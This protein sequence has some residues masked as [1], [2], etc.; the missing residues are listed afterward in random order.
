MTQP[1]F[2]IFSYL[3]NPRIYKATIAGRLCGV[4]VDIVGA[5]PPELADWLWDFNARSLDEAGKQQHADSARQARTGFGGTLYKTDAFLA[6]HPYGTVPAGFSADGQVG[7]F[8]SNSIMRAVARLGD[9]SAG[10]YGDDAVTAARVDSFLDVALVF[11]RDSQIYLLSLR[12]P[13]LTAEVYGACREALHHWLGGIETALAAGSKFI[14]RNQLTLADICF[15]CELALLKNEIGA[16]SNL[17]KLNLGP[18]TSEVEQ[19]FPR[20]YGHF[21]ALCEHDAF[22][23]DLRPYL[24]KLAAA[25]GQDAA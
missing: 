1:R 3:P 17:A 19:R 18:M 4:E 24:H 16:R 12:S 9:Q 22:S 14:A 5:K 6:A 21:Q 10:I 8:E 7:V 23:P 11:A 15:A 13:D 25:A 2:R 20:A